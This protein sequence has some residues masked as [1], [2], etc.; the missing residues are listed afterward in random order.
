M[1]FALFWLYHSL[2]ADL[3]YKAEPHICDSCRPVQSSFF[4][5]LKYD[6]LKHFFLIL[7]QRK[8]VQHK[9]VSFSQLAGC[10]S[11]RYTGLLCMIL[12][13]VHYS[14]QTSMHCAAF[15]IS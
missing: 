4:F 15:I 14:V 10:K 3:F 13:K 1:L 8:K 2:F 12:Y 11:D 9:T 7:A 5:H 6:M